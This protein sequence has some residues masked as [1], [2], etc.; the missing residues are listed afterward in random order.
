MYKYLHIIKINCQIFF[1]GRWFPS[2]LWKMRRHLSNSSQKR[3]LRHFRAL[4]FFTL[5]N[6]S[7]TN[8]QLQ[9]QTVGSLPTLRVTTIYFSFAISISTNFVQ[10]FIRNIPCV[11]VR[12]RA[13]QLSFQEFE[14]NE[15]P[16]KAKARQKH[17]VN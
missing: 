11:Y 8:S 9:T 13:R 12:L 10:N 17:I 1:L 4:I 15:D 5:E 3:L 16:L 2:L 7:E 14:K 6:I